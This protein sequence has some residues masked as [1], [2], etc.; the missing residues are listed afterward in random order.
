STRAL[1][2]VRHD[3]NRSRAAGALRRR[4]RDEVRR[5]GAP[6]AAAPRDAREPR[7]VPRRAARAPRERASP[8]AR[9]RTGSGAPGHGERSGVRSTGRGRA[10]G[11]RRPRAPRR[12]RRVPLEEGARVPRSGVRVRARGRAARSSVRDRIAAGRRAPALAPPRTSDLRNRP[13][14]GAPHLSLDFGL[15][16]EGR[17][18]TE[19]VLEAEFAFGARSDSSA[20]ASTT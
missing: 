9:A 1:L 10:L 6:R 19:A 4:V 16:P 8:V 7:A 11:R 20:V 14:L 3:P 13:R 5:A 15:A 2:A 12:P 17:V 18:E